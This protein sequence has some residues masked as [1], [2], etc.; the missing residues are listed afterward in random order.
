MQRIL[1]PVRVVNPYAHR[2]ILPES[3]LKKRRS[4]QLYLKF[5][6][7]ITLYHQHQRKRKADLFSEGNYIETTLSDIAWANRLLKEVLLSKSDELSGACRRFLESLKTHLEG[8]GQ[9]SFYAKEVRQALRL[10][11]S[12]L[13]RYLIELTRNG[14][15]TIRAG[16]KAKG[17]RY[18]AV[19]YQEYSQL[20]QGVESV[21]DEL[22]AQLQAEEASKQNGKAVSSPVVQ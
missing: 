10:N 11:A 20:R 16:S 19:S 14:Y 1:R 2:L 21:L 4:D 9:S 8:Q 17:Y 13:K 12:N 15:L 7:T 5:I 18:E 3:V 22:L 6:E